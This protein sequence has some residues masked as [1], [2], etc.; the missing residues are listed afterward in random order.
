MLKDIP[1]EWIKNYVD[2]IIKVAKDLPEDS[3][4]RNACL[5]RA[6]Y[7]MDLVKAFRETK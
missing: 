1:Q 6:E 3:S 2:Q 7:I 5:L 4:M